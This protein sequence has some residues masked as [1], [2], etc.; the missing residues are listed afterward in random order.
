MNFQSL[1]SI[2]NT[3]KSFDVRIENV[4]EIE[5]TYPTRYIIHCGCSLGRSLIIPNICL[6]KV[7][8][9]CVNLEH[10]CLPE[11]IEIFNFSKFLAPE[12]GGGGSARNV[13][14]RAVVKP[15]LQPRRTK[16]MRFL[17]R[18]WISGT[19]SKFEFERCF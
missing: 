18:P 10:K 5:V 9:S 14:A 8:S 6:V 4:L 17:P 13:F 11:H 1:V 3:Y 7:I 16:L 15:L 2:I 12:G 19:W